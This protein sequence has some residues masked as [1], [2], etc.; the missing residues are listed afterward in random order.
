MEENKQEV[1]RL[2]QDLIRFDT[3]NPPGNE[4]PAA[5]F[6]KNVF[7]REG[8]PCEILASEPDRGSFLAHLDET[9]RKPSLLLLSHLDVVPATEIQSWKHPPFSGALDDGWIYGRGAIDTK[10]LTAAETMA[11]ILLKR[12]GVKLKGT[13]KLAAVAD[14]ERGGNLGA[15][16]LTAKLPSKV[17]ADYVINEGGGLVLKTKTG[18]LYLVEAEEKGI[19]WIK[20]TAKGVARHASIPELGVSAVAKMSEA[21]ARISRHRTKIKPSPTLRRMLGL[22]MERQSGFSGK[23]MAKLLLDTPFTDTILNSIRK[24]EPELAATL[25]ALMRPTIAETMIKGG[26]KENVIPDYCEAIIDSRL[27]VGVTKDDMVRELREAMGNISGIEIEAIQYSLASTSPIDNDFY[28][29]LRK[30][31]KTT[32]GEQAEVAPF[33]VTGATDSRYLRPLGA[34]AY[35]FAPTSPDVDYRQ[36]I[37]LVHGV[38][39]RINVQSLY[40]CTDFLVEMCKNFLS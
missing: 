15:G 14:E 30:T 6:L 7:D 4:T 9:S 11:M 24:R 33:V 20:L 40:T 28:A 34:I 38:N 12:A 36:L 18:P 19:C 37:G 32:V 39:E 25:S 10:Y 13:L 2:L 27:P 29:T 23:I 3:T 5:E 8:I 1:V 17:S 31:L 35:G 26:V 21:L 16:W 22:V